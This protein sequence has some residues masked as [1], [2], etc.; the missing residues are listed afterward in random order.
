MFESAI[1]L[2]SISA[3]SAEQ[4]IAVSAVSRRLSDLEHRLGTAVLYRKGRGVEPT[5]AGVVLLRHA[6]NLLGLAARASDDMSDFAGGNRGQVRLAANPSAV[7]QFL[8]DV[9]AEFMKD[10]PGVKIALTEAVSDV[11][12]QQIRDGIV[13][14]GIFSA[15]VSSDG[16]ETFP[17][18]SDRLCAVVPADHPLAESDRVPFAGI[19]PYPH[20]ALADGSSLFAL[21]AG[22]AREQGAELNVSVSVRSFDGVRRMVAHGLGIAVLPAGVTEPYAESDGLKAVALSDPWAARQFLAG[23]RERKALSR[24]AER[25]LSRL[26]MMA[27]R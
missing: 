1:R 10:N 21:I 19:I 16:L 18:L 23:V 4:N 6:E 9:L 13:D 2:G 11:I 5:P 14:A 20:V 15:G 22:A 7:A 3:A 12:V 25:F 26:L 24:P 8:P 17:M 27:G